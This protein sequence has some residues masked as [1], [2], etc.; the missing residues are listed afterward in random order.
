MDETLLSLKDKLT[1]HCEK[2]SGR[3]S[4]PCIIARYFIIYT[5][6]SHFSVQERVS[7]VRNESPLSWNVL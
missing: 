6:C 3:K 7:E 5:L 1:N 2:V 4:Q